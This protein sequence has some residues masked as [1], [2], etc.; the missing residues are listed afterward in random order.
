MRLKR[1]HPGVTFYPA[2]IEKSVVMSDV[3]DITDQELAQLMSPQLTRQSSGLSEMKAVVTSR[4][5]AYGVGVGLVAGL[6]GMHLLHKYKI[7]K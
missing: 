7:M 6:V 2:G 3:S 4:N 1:R 5:Y